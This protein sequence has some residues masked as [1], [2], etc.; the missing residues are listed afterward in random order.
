MA[1]LVTAATT[2]GVTFWISFQDHSVAPHT[3]WTTPGC[4]AV[5]GNWHDRSP[6]WTPTTEGAAKKNRKKPPVVP[7]LNE[8]IPLTQLWQNSLCGN[9]VSTIS[10][11]SATKQEELQTWTEEEEMVEGGKE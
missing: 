5:T 1:L 2:V 4:T 9:V 11:S 7:S 10:S 8:H 6:W 3:T